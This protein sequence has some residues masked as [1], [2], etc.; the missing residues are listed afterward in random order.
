MPK[1]ELD[2]GKLDAILQFN[3]TLVICA[4]L[5]EISI[6]TIER[7]I[8][9][10]H[11]CT[12]LEYKNRKMGLVKIKLQQKAIT[13]AL[14]GNTAM[15]IFTLKNLCGWADKFVHSE[16]PSLKQVPD[17]EQLTAEEKQTILKLIKSDAAG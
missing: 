17:L 5:L 10:A 16:D 9:D 3:P 6:D 11:N 12:F 4:E 14:G 15:M 13:M 1:I 7:R 8:K 2:W